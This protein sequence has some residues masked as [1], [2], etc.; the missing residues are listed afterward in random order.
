MP[1]S[2]L[3]ARVASSLSVPHAVRC[4][5]RN[6]TRSINTV[7]RAQYCRQIQ[8]RPCALY[9]S[10]R[11]LSGDAS[12]Q[13]QTL[14]QAHE[15]SGSAA[16]KSG[17]KPEFPGSRSQFIDRLAFIDPEQY[18]GIPVYRVMNRDGVVLSADQDPNLSREMITKMYK[19][20]TL[21]NFMDRVLYESQRQGRISF[22]MTNYG[23]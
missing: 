15:A 22:Y 1:V 3:F 7:S 8:S 4:S 17:E 10:Y 20:M 21:L 23:K 11:S 2:R 13:Q 5:I 9:N 16:Y 18:E 14:Q 6:S 19:G 12:Q